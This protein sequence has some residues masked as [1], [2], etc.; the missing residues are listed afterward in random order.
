MDFQK[1]Y[2]EAVL[3]FIGFTDIATV[4]VEPTLARGPEHAAQA[5]EKAVALACEKARS[6]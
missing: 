4:L 5:L 2:L 6:F 1:P 3:R